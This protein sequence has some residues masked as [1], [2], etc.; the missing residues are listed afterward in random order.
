M[1]ACGIRSSVF[2]LGRKERESDPSPARHRDPSPGMMDLLRPFRVDSDLNW[3]AAPSSD[4]L[5]EAAEVL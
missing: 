5:E 3:E 4:K 1:E 2:K